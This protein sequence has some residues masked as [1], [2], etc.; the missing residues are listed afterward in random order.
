MVKV[1]KN[2]V[3]RA[4][5]AKKQIQY[6]NIRIYV[7]AIACAVSSVA[8][9]QSTE[10]YSDLIQRTETLPAYEAMYYML[11]FQRSHPDNAP[12]YYRLGDAVYALLPSKDALHNYEER[13]ELIYRARLFYGNCL[14]F[15][16]GRMPRGETFPTITPA[17]KKLEY[18]DIDAYL[19]AHLDTLNRWRA[20]TDTLH[21]RFYRMVDSYE[22][23]RQLFLQFMQRYPSE[24]LAHLCLTEDD[25]DHLFRL[26]RIN[27]EFEQQKAL[28]EQALQASP[29]PYYTPEFRKV[30]IA[31]YRLDGVT[32]SDFLANDIP[33]WDY[34]G[35]AS[36]FLD[37]Q[38]NTYLVLMRDLAQEYT[39]L[40]H[41]MQ[42]F[43]EGQSIEMEAQPRLP[44]R[45]ERYDYQSPVAMLLRLQQLVA[46]T[47]LQAADSLTTATQI[48]DAEL[49]VRITANIETQQ[50]IEEAN[51][52]MQKFKQR[53]ND[54]TAQKYSFFLRE[55]KMDSVEGMIS[56]A[57]Q[58]LAFQEE[59]TRLIDR[60]LQNYAE[61]F[62]KQFKAV[63]ISDDFAA[64]QA[65][66]A[67]AK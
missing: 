12:I 8:F 50:R 31:T 37:I 49:S 66:E 67:A 54:L 18:S 13:N 55:T 1:M 58:L 23:C 5:V 32:P 25:R 38:K 62:P 34:E 9:A 4:L 44:Y 63:D 52:L 27:Q 14:H 11:D 20:E 10:R 41:G 64:S 3:N 36:A 19:R 2:A 53:I 28:F 6:K 21:N 30:S 24:K 40:N 42:R 48:S 33:L 60:Q 51:T 45:L 59:L 7:C 43:R 26:R 39:Q 16:G 15:L 65:A 29:V 17:D 56:S 57:E 35:W 61:A 22:S 47:T 46:G